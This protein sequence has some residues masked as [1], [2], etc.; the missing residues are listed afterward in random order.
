VLEHCWPRRNCIN[1]MVSTELHRDGHTEMFA[2][3]SIADQ[4][5]KHSPVRGKCFILGHASHG[6]CRVRSRGA[7]PA[8]IPSHNHVSSYQCCLN[9]RS[10][11]FRRWDTNWPIVNKA[12]LEKILLSFTAAI[13]PSFC[14][15]LRSDTHLNRTDSPPGPTANMGSSS[16]ASEAPA[17]TSRPRQE[18]RCFVCQR[19]YE[20]ADH[21]NR[22]LKSRKPSR[23]ALCRRQ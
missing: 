13:I 7:R 23:S 22:H 12:I 10:P 21:L 11:D 8:T 6:A 14:R 16:P 4:E 19:T 2:F 18:H 1:K 5:N 17:G 20:R 3:H 9:D 15:N